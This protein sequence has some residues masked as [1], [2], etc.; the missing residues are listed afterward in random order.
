MGRSASQVVSPTPTPAARATLHEVGTAVVRQEYI[1][2]TEEMLDSAVLA[3]LEDWNIRT[4]TARVREGVERQGLDFPTSGVTPT[5]QS[6]NI[7][8]DGRKL[9]M[10]E[11]EAGNMRIVRILGVEPQELVWV[12]CYRESLEDI[13]LCSGPC[14]T[15]IQSALGVSAKA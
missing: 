15:E 6:A 9:A 10:F 12:S 7:E 11:M 4:L 8:I 13:P 2:L 14:G 3:E 5:I 1:G